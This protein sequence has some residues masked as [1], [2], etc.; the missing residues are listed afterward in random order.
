MCKK[1][2]YFGAARLFMFETIKNRPS[3][4]KKLAVKKY[5]K[6]LQILDNLRLR[7]KELDDE[8][9]ETL[10]QKILLFFNVQND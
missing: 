5:Q 2:I 6:M 7:N 9:L 3:K 4:T 10:R 8:F 1:S